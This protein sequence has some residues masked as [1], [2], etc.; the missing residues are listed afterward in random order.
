MNIPGAA[1]TAIDTARGELAA[2]QAKLTSSAAAIAAAEAQVDALRRSGAKAAAIAAAEKKLTTLTAQHRTLA[3][4]VRTAVDKVAQ[5]SESLV[6]AASPEQLVSSLDGRVPVALLPTRIETRFFD[7]GSQL[8]VRIYPDQIHVDA[9]EPELTAAEADSG[10]TYWRAR[11]GADAAAETVAWRELA[12]KLGAARAAYVARV[13]TP[14]NAASAAPGV[15]PKFPTVK[16]RHAGWTRP[17]LARALPDRWVVVGYQDGVEVFRKWGTAVADDLATGPTP[18]PVLAGETLPSNAAAEEP[19]AVDEG[20][21]WV[22]DYDAA[23]RAGM[24]ITVVDADLAAGHRLRDGLDRLVVFGVDW[25][26]APEAAATSLTALLE[27]HLHTD[28]F[29]FVPQGT[30]TNNTG[31]LRSGY[32]TDA[33]ALTDALDPGATRP[34]PDASWS[35]VALLARALGISVAGS[36]LPRAP[37]ADVV[38]RRTAGAMTDVLWES[39]WGH[40]LDQLLDPL[41]DDDTIGLV[42]DHASRFVAA[43]GPVPVLR[44]GKHPYGLLPVVASG[45]YRGDGIAADIATQLGRLRGFWLQGSN[46]VPQMTTTRD[47]D[48]TL[49]EI[50]QRTPLAAT[51]RYRRVLGPVAVANTAGLEQVA[52]Q[53]Q[54]RNLWLCRFVFD[55]A[56]PPRLA[57][58]TTDVA[59]PAPALH[60]PWVVPE[61]IPLETPAPAYVA[62]VAA[63]VRTQGGRSSLATAQNDPQSLLHALLACAAVG[64]IDRA[65]ARFLH[66]HLVSVGAAVATTKAMPR[67]AELLHVEADPAQGG[68]AFAASAAEQTRLVVPALTGSKSLGEFVAAELVAAGAHEKPPLRDINMFLAGVDFLASRP[69]D[70]LD[71][72]FRGVLDCCSHRL[73]AWYTSLAARRLDD[74]RTTRPVGVHVGGWGVVEDLKPDT[75][76]DSLGYVHAP[77]LAQAATAAILRSGH[78]AHHDDEHDALAIDLRSDRVRLAL[79][80]LDGVAQGQP[81]AALLGYRFERGVRDRDIRLARFILPIR[82]LAPLRPTGEPGPG[83]QPLEAVAARDVVDG[84][85]LAERWRDERATL[86]DTLG[87]SATERDALSAELDRLEDAL[88]AVSDVLVAEAVYQNVLGNPERAGAALAA[89]DRQDRPVSPEVVQTPRTGHSLTH[90]L[91]VLFP[92]A[93]PPAAW[94]SFPVDPR[95]AAEPRANAWVARVLGDPA[96]YAVAAEVH[97]AEGKVVEKL[98]VRLAELELSPLALVLA[99]AGG[100]AEQPTEL[101]ERIAAVAARK[102]THGSPDSSLVLLPEPPTGAPAGAAGL[103]ALLAAVNA[104]RGVLSGRRA[105]DARDLALPADAADPQVDAAELTARADAAVGSL[106]AA[107]TA[108]ATATAAATPNAAKL[109]AAL[110]L[111]AQAGAPAAAPRIDPAAEGAAAVLADQARQVLAAVN[112]TAKRVADANAAF[113]ALTPPPTH[114]QVVAHQVGRIKQV[115][116]DDFP[117]LPLFRPYAPSAAELGASLGDQAALAGAKNAAAAGWL[118]RMALVR[119]AAEALALALTAA[120]AIRRDVAVTNL[121]VAQLPHGPGARWAALPLDPKAGPPAAEVSFAINAPAGTPDLTKPLAG[122]AV[123]EWSELIPGA[124]ET[125]GLTFHYDAP[126]ARA[127]NVIVLAVP[128]DPAA[129]QWSLDALLDTVRETLELARMRSVTPKELSFLGGFLPATYL[130]FTPK[131]DE[132]SIDF[133]KLRTKFAVAEEIATVLGKA[134]S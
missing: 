71:R 123:D 22:S 76:P 81:L 119:P 114:D 65:A 125:T 9:H 32:T 68:G 56:R 38:E 126:A 122:I 12:R 96:R 106:T 14:T 13:L 133:S 43:S 117:V 54:L 26:V 104:V 18:D 11:F 52:E 62:Q 112:A 15:A 50:L 84:V 91:L 79:G 111:A 92:E 34:A 85:R 100:S 23:V 31:A 59:E 51:A 121:V 108:L 61:P 116:G 88:D 7:G 124:S 28:G 75:R 41:L 93:K 45:R 110:S 19:L 5:A 16:S 46:L 73:D 48:A 87:A 74:L 6:A 2:A 103:A 58:L 107:A 120:G 60:M 30:P 33:K 24:A 98:A 77:S 63:L 4:G 78:L 17:P 3:T 10:R 37:Y 1:L 90:R 64:E 25:T 130:P 42:R 27:A 35:A 128:P 86:L 55:L 102:A 109:A 82:M 49:L 97:D 69:A 89:L 40:Y 132:P 39:T 57:S 99:G 20:L 113:S 29:G 115:F 44:V 67:Y 70:E 131:P 66:G 80:L 72:A 8:R 95:A 118:A 134:V 53:Q 127:P 129:Q 105:V 101:E 94:G 36:D 83:A 47:P 21:R